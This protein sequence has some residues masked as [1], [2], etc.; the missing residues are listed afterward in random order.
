MCGFGLLLFPFHLV[1]AAHATP[2]A[3]QDQTAAQDVEAL[4]LAA[5]QGDAGAQLQLGVIYE[6]GVAGSAWRPSK[7]TPSDSSSSG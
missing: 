1:G 4:R 5:E 7:G 3:P 2:A 6:F